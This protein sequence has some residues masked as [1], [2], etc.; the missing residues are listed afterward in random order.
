[1]PSP[2]EPPR[3]FPS[4]RFRDAEAMLAWLTGT[5]GF[6]V[7]MRHPETGPIDH[8]ELAYGSAIIMFGQVR[9]DAFGAKSPAPGGAVTYIAVEDVDALFARV[10]ASGV[11]IEEAPTERDYGSREFVCRDADGNLWCF[12]TYWP[13]AE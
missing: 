9:D 7:V 1:M 4:F 12:G 11:A 2:D 10:E 6:T 13:K 5:V 8:A 3:I